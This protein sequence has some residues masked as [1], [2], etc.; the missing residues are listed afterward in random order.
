MNMP[1]KSYILT[2]ESEVD[3]NKIYDY[4]QANYSSIK[5]IEYLKSFE[6]LFLLL[7]QN[8]LLGRLR[9]E[10]YLD[11]YSIRH[12]EYI[13]YYKISFEELLIIRII[14]QKRDPIR[15]ME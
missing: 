13:V 4:T 14:H 9:K 12:R 15:F 7:L 2:N 8:P 5:A 6:E 3:L 10:L 1:L 11:V